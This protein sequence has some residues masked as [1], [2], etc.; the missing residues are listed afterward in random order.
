MEVGPGGSSCISNLTDRIAPFDL[1]ADLDMDPVEVSIPSDD[2]VT[3]VDD[4]D[5]PISI[6]SPHIGDE[7]IR[8]SNDR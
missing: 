1:L 2:A 8:W 5:L 6:L 4:K 3:V 7:P